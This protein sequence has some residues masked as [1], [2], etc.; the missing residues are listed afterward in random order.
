MKGFISKCV[1]PLLKPSPWLLL[2]FVWHSGQVAAS[3]VDVKGLSWLS[4][5]ES[6]PADRGVFNK[7]LRQSVREAITLPSLGGLDRAKL[8][9]ALTP[10]L[11]SADKALSNYVRVS[12]NIDHYRQLQMLMPALIK[13]EERK[14][15]LHLFAQ[16][17]IPSPRLANSRLLPILDKRITRLADGMI[18][19]MKALVR[20]QRNHE[21]DLLKAMSAY[22]IKFSARP[23]DFF[24]EY[25]L[26]SNGRN[27]DRL[28]Q[29]RGSIQLLNKYQVPI[30]SAQDI[31]KLDTQNEDDARAQTL[32]KMAEQIT[33]QLK[34]TLI[35][36]GFK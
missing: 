12:S 19:N 20:Q 15:I 21:A 32:K 28:W 3:Q 23:P 18:F 25:E 5:V 36:E 6:M 9:K 16:N 8:E 11:I 22:G 30:A 26:L 10:H 14:L 1:S 35:E 17:E 33:K 4:V 24:L 2:L 13:I 27:A 34:T 31:F 7:S 29:L